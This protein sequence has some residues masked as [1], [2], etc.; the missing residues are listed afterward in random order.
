MSAGRLLLHN[1][2]AYTRTHRCKPVTDRHRLP[3]S[4][5]SSAPRLSVSRRKQPATGEGERK[6]EETEP[7]SRTLST[8]H[9]VTHDC[10]R[11]R[12]NRRSSPVTLPF[13]ACL[14]L[15]RRSLDNDSTGGA[16]LR[17]REREE[18]PCKRCERLHGACLRCCCCCCCQLLHVTR[19]P[20]RV[21]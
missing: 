2:H 14:L 16:R 7:E 15:E 3:V 5:T 9:R 21:L 17:E 1:T 12:D 20:I 11:G 10:E 4:L 18:R 8:G 13:T 6:R 19:S